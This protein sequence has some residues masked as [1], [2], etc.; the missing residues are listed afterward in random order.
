MISKIEVSVSLKIVKLCKDE[1]RKRFEEAKVRLEE[2][3]QLSFSC[4]S[5]AFSS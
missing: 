1:R 3:R 4:M 5:A 2:K